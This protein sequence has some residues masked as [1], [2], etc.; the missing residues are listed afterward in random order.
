MKCGTDGNAL[1]DVT[2]NEYRC[3]CNCSEG[4]VF[5]EESSSCVGE[6]DIDIV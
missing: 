4:T 3:V 1:I 6:F 5:D 2:N